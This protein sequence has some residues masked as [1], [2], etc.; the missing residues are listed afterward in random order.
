M[1]AECFRDAG[2]PERVFNY[3][4]GQNEPLG[5]ALLDSPDVDGITFTGSYA[6]GMKIYRQSANFRYPRPLALEMGGKNAAV[7]SGSADVERAAR[8]IVRSGFGA[9][10]QKYS[11]SSRVYAEDGIY[12]K[13]LERIVE[14][15][16]SLQVG[17]PTERHIDLGP[18]I[19]ERSY[20]SY[21][22]YCRQ[23]SKAGN[24]VPGGRT[25]SQD[26]FA[27]GYYCEPTVVSKVPREHPLWRD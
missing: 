3:V 4:T 10:G 17:D 2:L 26:G 27:K 15:T 8:G 14:I 13:L 21:I 5:Q 11:A 20:Q 24:I 9:Q 16:K 23:W 1:L 6:V 22:Q 12:D 19:R 7:V 25:L 18:L